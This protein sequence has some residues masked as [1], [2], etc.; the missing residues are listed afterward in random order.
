MKPEYLE[1]PLVKNEEKNQFEITIDGHKAFIL[2]KEKP[3]ATALIH[4]ETE[5]EL[6]GKGAGTAV[7]EKTLAYIEEHNSK[8]IPLCPFVFAY[9]KRHPEWKRIVDE[10][11]KGF[12]E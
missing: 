7:I 11:F 10:H 1:I 9:I 8:I 3:Y 6:E 4:T 2:Y 5:P 12:D